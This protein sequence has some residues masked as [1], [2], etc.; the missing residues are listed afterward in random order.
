MRILNMRP[1]K[2]HSQARVFLD[3]LLNSGQFSELL[4]ELKKLS[5]GIRKHALDPRDVAIYEAHALHGLGKLEPSARAFERAIELDGRDGS[6]FFNA[7]I[8]RFQLGHFDIAAEHFRAFLGFNVGAREHLWAEL[9]LDFSALNRERSISASQRS[10]VEKY[11]P[12]PDVEI[13]SV[14]MVNLLIFGLTHSTTDVVEILERVDPTTDEERWIVRIVNSYRRGGDASALEEIVHGLGSNTETTWWSLALTLAER[15]KDLE[16]QI[17]IRKLAKARGVDLPFLTSMLLANVSGIGSLADDADRRSKFAKYALSQ[18]EDTVPFDSLYMTDDPNIQKRVGMT[19]AAKHYGRLRRVKAHSQKNNRLRLGFFSADFNNHAIG[20]LTR[21]LYSTLEDAGA[22]V[23]LYNFSKKEDSLTEAL[24]KGVKSY[25]N[26]SLMSTADLV[27]EARANK[28]DIAYDMMGYTGERRTEIFAMGIAP[29]H[30]N[31]LG[32][33]GTLGT[34]FHDYIIAD[35]VLIPSQSE[36]FYTERVIRMPTTYQPN[37]FQ[38]ERPL[39]DG[40]QAGGTFTFIFASFNATYKLSSF[41]ANK[42]IEILT[43]CPN[44]ELWLLEEGGTAKNNMADYFNQRNVD[45]SRI[46][47]VDRKSPIEHL[48]RHNSVDLFLD[49]GPYGAHTTAS[50]ALWMG[51]PVLTCPG[52]TFASRVAASLCLAHVEADKVVSTPEAYVERACDLYDAGKLSF[53]D[54]NERAYRDTPLF[55][56]AAYSDAFLEAARRML[57]N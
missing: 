16:N 5:S 23:Y 22:E 45:P 12:L 37:D 39:M 17:H 19:W 21:S 52:K 8:C 35:H 44:S 46:K 47:F 42:W 50:D 55:D 20:H 34:K 10:L 33:P 38:R 53:R 15:L 49:S 2:K 13:R 7:G 40:S 25:R 31:Y 54:R 4:S 57:G 51:V 32:Y 24:S 28:L 3:D 30:V 1:Q 26:V 56:T 41:W 27:L 9:Y 36:R 11:L 6:D 48:K 29:V 43:R 18:P 14:A